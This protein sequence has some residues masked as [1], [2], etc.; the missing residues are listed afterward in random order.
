MEKV[1]RARCPSRESEGPARVLEDCEFAKG[2]LSSRVRRSST[3]GDCELGK[4]NRN[5]R[6]QAYMRV[7]AR[8]Y[9]SEEKENFLRVLGDK[10]G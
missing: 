5:S 7:H 6:A 9:M 8:D 3:D 4:G 2:K 1:T 10:V